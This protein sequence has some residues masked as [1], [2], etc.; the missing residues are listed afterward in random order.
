V[1]RAQKKKLL[2]K[3][4]LKIRSLLLKLPLRLLPSRLLCRILLPL[5]LQRLLT[6]L[7]LLLSLPSNS[8][9]K[10]IK[11]EPQAP[12][13]FSTLF[14]DPGSQAEHPEVFFPENVPTNF[15]NR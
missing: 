13:L 8:A 7:L 9:Q 15:C 14:I 4:L 10:K 12:F 3:K 1:V 5:L 2:R 11:K 6:L